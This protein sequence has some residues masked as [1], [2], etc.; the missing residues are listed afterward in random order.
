MKFRRILLSKTE[1]EIFIYIVLVNL[2]K[3]ISNERENTEI[4]KKQNSHYSLIFRPIDKTIK[5]IKVLHQSDNIGV[6]HYGV[7]WT[8]EKLVKKYQFSRL[9]IFPQYRV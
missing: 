8:H 5:N 7:L 9:T 1:E 3:N 4:W 6:L 2:L